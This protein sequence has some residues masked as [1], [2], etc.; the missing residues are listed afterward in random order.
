MSG[1]EAG[2]C[3]PCDEATSRLGSDKINELK[4]QLPSGWN[5]M[6]EHHLEKLYKFPDFKKALDF[7]NR[8]GAIAE[9][10]G[11]HPDIYLTWGKV[12]LTIYTHKVDGLTEND[13]Q[14]A[15]K[16]EKSLG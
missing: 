8:V 7:T 15:E 6:E 14:L 2:K 5:V 1:N 9:E 3:Q 13:F 16:F 11:H 10:T 4:K 12:R